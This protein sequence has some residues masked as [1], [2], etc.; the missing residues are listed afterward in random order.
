[1]VYSFCDGV[2]ISQVTFEAL[3]SVFIAIAQLRLS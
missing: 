3:H 2:T 1:M